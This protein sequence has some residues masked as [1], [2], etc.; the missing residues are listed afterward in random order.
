M[1]KTPT[2]KKTLR[3]TKNVVRNLTCADLEQVA[4]GCDTTS[5]TTEGKTHTLN[6][7]K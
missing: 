3:L 6:T 7:A 4:A 2:P 1:K 5:V